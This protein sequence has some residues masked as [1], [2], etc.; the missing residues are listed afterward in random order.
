MLEVV[1]WIMQRHNIIV[2]KQNRPIHIKLI[3]ILNIKED[4]TDHTQ[5]IVLVWLQLEGQEL[6]EHIVVPQ[7]IDYIYFM[8]LL[9]SI[10]LALFI[11]SCAPSEKAKNT[12]PYKYRTKAQVDA[13]CKAQIEENKNSK[14]QADSN[15]GNFLLG[16][17]M[18][19]QEDWACD[20]YR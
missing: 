16:V 15:A 17:M 14:A 4:L 8:K 13:A 12:I 10:S 9:T 6:W 1:T 11:F 20:P 18:A 2:I 5:V 3:I 19:M 7:N